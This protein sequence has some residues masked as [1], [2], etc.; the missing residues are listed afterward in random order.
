MGILSGFIFT[1]THGSSARVLPEERAT[2]Q[3]SSH[4]QLVDPFYV[5]VVV[6]IVVGTEVGE[7]NRF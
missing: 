6:Q 4:P 7:R 1:C 5:G 3:N 2:S